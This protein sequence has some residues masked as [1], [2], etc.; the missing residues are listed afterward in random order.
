MNATFLIARRELGSY[1]RTLT[2]YIIAAILL[3]V[4][5]L[6][7]NIFAL[8][9]GEKLSAE[10]IGQFFF[11]TSGLTVIASI[12][13]SMRLLAE[14]RQTGTLVLLTSSPVHDVEIVLGKFLSALFF[15]ALVLA[16]SV[17]MPLLVLVNGKVS[18]GHLL[19]GYLGLLLIGG[20]SLAIGTFGSAI[21]RTQ[22]LAV[23]FSASIT[24][25]MVVC[26]ML[27]KVT[28]RP[29]SDVFVALAFHGKHFPPFQSGTV[30]LRDVIYYLMVTYVA[31]FSATRVLESRRWK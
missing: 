27:S 4:D 22:V 20:A 30:H 16:A 24:L 23:I 15:L 6:L 21:A 18:A 2:G 12:F 25:A 31:L 14:E 17:Y 8:G 10:V 28:E 9:G 13:L 7:F 11:Y 26:W 5:G 29:L 3:L 19:A 1:F